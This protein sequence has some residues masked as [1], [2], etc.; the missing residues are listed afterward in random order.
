MTPGT[1]SDNYAALLARFQ[2]RPIQSEAEAARVQI[3]IDRLIDQGDLTDDKRAFLNLLG[4]LVIV[5]EDGRYD[6]PDISGAEVI[7]SLLEDT[8]HKQV[9]LVGP[10][11]PT[12]SVASEVIS[13]K[14][15]LN[16]AYVEKLSRFFG[17]SPALFY[18]EPSPRWR[19]VQ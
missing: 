4:D 6:L 13:G 17:V 16:Y 9:D 5:W 8:G 19:A 1:A 15:K 14:R 7:R 18:P 11:F 2:P 12:R 3:E 10:V